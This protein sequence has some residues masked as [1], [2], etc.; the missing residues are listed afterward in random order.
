MRRSAEIYLPSDN[1]SCKLPELPEGRFD[2]TQ[3]EH[4]A[5][6]GHTNSTEITCDL[7]R[8][9]SWT[10]QSLRLREKRVDHVSWATESGVYLIGG[11]Y[12]GKTSELVKEGGSVA[13]FPLKYDT[14]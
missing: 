2:H 3:D 6:G 1:S 5:C 10:R 8:E 9:G 4:W 14:E 7:W 12:S 13:G 11:K